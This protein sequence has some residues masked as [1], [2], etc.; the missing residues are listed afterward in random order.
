[1]ERLQPAHFVRAWVLGDTRRAIGWPRLLWDTMPCT[2]WPFSGVKACTSP[3]LKYRR[4]STPCAAQPCY[5]GPGKVAAEGVPLDSSCDALCSCRDTLQGA[6]LLQ[7]A[8][9]AA[10]QPAACSR[11]AWAGG[12]QVSQSYPSRMMQSWHS[13]VSSMAYAAYDQK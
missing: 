13:S 10:W 12:M 7:C 9:V 1:M 11:Y 4:P 3:W 6:K 5:E 8:I 2:A